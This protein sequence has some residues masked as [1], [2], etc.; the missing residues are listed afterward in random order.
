MTIELA[1]VI[2]EVESSGRA[3]EFRFEPAL[4]EAWRAELQATPGGVKGAIAKRVAAIHPGCS[5]PTATV[6]A[7]TSW[8][9]YQLLGENLYDGLWSRPILEFVADPAG[10]RDAFGEFLIRH[11]ID[12][13]LT[14]LIQD[15]DKRRR[16]I[17]VYNGPGA[18]DAYWA[19]IKRAVVA[20]GGP[21]ILA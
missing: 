6:I 9:L 17:E 15:T 5:L 12:V 10:Q 8:G 16:F 3:A 4:Y 18:V 20:L 7:C 1:D 19:E 14:E 11:D 13:T 2:A 21:Q